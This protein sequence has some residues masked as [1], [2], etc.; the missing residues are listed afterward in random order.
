MQD[1][2]HFRMHD[3]SLVALFPYMPATTNPYT[4]TCYEHIGQHGEAD[5]LM[6]IEEGTPADIESE[7][8]Q[9]LIRELT[10]RDY[11]LK[12]AKRA[13]SVRHSLQK[14]KAE[15]VE[16]GHTRYAQRR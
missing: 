13:P 3:D 11:D 2:V 8:V 6:M 15:L 4:C 12:I 7:E 10:N 5:Y 16:A 14:R 1:T 9:A